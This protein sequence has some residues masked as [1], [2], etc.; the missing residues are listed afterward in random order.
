MVTIGGYG[1][2]ED[3][4]FAALGARNVDTF[5][6]VR[7]RRGL[8]GRRYAFLNSTR[9]QDRLG[10]LGI[11]YVH[12]RELAPTS[13]LRYTQKKSDAELGIEKRRRK[14]LSPAFIHAYEE[15]ILAGFR[16]DD[17]FA[18]LS[19]D[20]TVVAVFCVEGAPE[21]CHRSLIARRLELDDRITVE[22]VR[23]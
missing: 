18:K 5:V 17:F 15:E 23:P 11:R 4:F 19:T 6:D 22:H 1:F 12:L 14:E 13:A 21:A 2:S 20:S 16:A 10:R 3:K 8:R 9:L 7:Q